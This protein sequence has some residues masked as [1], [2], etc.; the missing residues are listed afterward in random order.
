MQPILSFSEASS[1]PSPERTLPQKTSDP[2]S[3]HL[4]AEEEYTEYERIKASKDAQKIAKAV[5]KE[6]RLTFVVLLDVFA[7]AMAV[8]K[9]DPKTA[10]NGDLVHL[11]PATI[12][13]LQLLARVLARGSKKSEPRPTEKWYELSVQYDLDILRRMLNEH[14]DRL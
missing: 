13:M 10:R 4:L 5:A 1:P 14:Y 2:L 6:D 3:L 12:A 7:R 9:V 8:A 11:G